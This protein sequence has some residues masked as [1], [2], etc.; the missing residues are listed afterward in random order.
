MKNRLQIATVVLVFG[1]S[2]ALQYFNVEYLGVGI[3]FIAGLC[4]SIVRTIIEDIQ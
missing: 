2:Y 3:G 1:I 4:Y